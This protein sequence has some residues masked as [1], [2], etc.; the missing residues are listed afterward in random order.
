MI[1]RNFALSLFLLGALLGSTTVARAASVDPELSAAVDAAPLGLTPVVI[2][3][4]H[5]PT[6]F[7]LNFL[8]LMGIPGGVVLNELPMV[9]TVVNSSQL[10]AL[11][12]RS[13]VVSLYSNRVYE[14]YLNASR[15]FVGLEA[16]RADVEVTAANG[17]LPVS[18]RGIGVAVIDTGI[19]ATHPDL[20]LGNNV[21]QNVFFPLAEVPE[22][23]PAGFIPPIYIEDMPLTDVEGGHGTFVAGNIGAT[24]QA[25]GGFYG[26]MAPDAD[27][28]GL[29]A[30][31]DGG[32][33]TFAIVQAYDYIMTHQFQYNIRVANNSFGSELGD[34]DNYDPFDP[35]NVGTRELHDRFVTVVFAAGND[36]D[37]PGAINRLSVAPWV[38]SVAAGEKEGRGNPAS[39]SSRG[40]DNGT[41][42]DVAGHPA[43]PLAPPNLRPDLIAPG[44]NIK[45][46]RS[47]APGVTN[48]AGTALLQDLDIPPAFLPYYTTS[49]GTSFS[50]PQVS[51]VVALMLEANPML[52]PD[53]IALVLRETSTPMP[54]EE[55]VVG[56]GFL[57][58]HNAVRAV[59]DLSAVDHPADLFPQ[60]GD[61]AI[62][63]SRG[64]Q[65]GTTAQDI[66][67][68]DF[69]VDEAT[70]ELV[71]SMELA[72]LETV[73][74]GMR[75]TQSSVFSGIRVFVSTS[76]IETT[77]I[78][79]DYGTIAPDPNTGVN[80]QTTIGPAD[81]VEL[82]G[83]QV[84]VRL[85]LD[86]I[87]A[88]VGYPVLGTSSTA[89]QAQT[90][91]LIGSSLTGGLLLSADS[92]NGS[93]FHL[94]DGSGDDGGDD[95]DNNPP[96]ACVETISERLA[97]AIMVGD[98]NREIAFSMRCTALNAKLNYHPGNQD[99]A[100]EL[101]DANGDWL[102]SGSSANGR[103][104]EIDGLA[105]GEY[106]YRVSGDLSKDVDF[107]I[108]STQEP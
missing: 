103:R 25:S 57:D 17:G 88:A 65:I 29:V 47:K 52:T 38:I 26:G 80:N 50:A 108:K 36:G 87:D 22:E 3:Y 9:L 48:L 77:A 13:G 49:Q 34:A 19:D 83:N 60:P 95:D 61:P 35:I 28:I 40:I 30:G 73:T 92:A 72:D 8:T 67:S 2:T 82:D 70:N 32:L 20:Q 93:D 101:L 41:G 58:A 15:K 99:V 6:A 79:A 98:S 94:D 78:E 75:W 39:F 7:D 55:R 106:F 44:S 63:D 66:I 33:S 90:Q 102:A 68:A 27:L 69:T 84:V 24:G 104:I 42:T 12:Q 97:G 100:F 18:G 14:P 81:W 1:S 64:D 53:E 23:P 43:D 10:D 54:F 89:S 45:S 85:S 105:P 91:I 86:K 21:V 56:A 11:Q 96:G 46:T 51:G 62:L 37:V 74:P 76:V 31:N 5:A 4:D 107:V 71:Y 16:L 59:L